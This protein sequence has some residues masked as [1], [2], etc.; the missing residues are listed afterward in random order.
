MI[1]EKL[2]SDKRLLEKQLFW[3]D[4]SY[5]ESVAI[6]IKQDYSIDESGRFETLCSRIL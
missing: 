5:K 1:K 6:E 3:L 4:I 2:L